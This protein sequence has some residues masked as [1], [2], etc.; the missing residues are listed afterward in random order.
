MHRFFIGLLCIAMLGNSA[1]AQ[2]PS[3]K[4]KSGLEVLFEKHLDLLRGKR[5]AL[6][7][8]PTGVNSKLESIIDL[9]KANP[10]IKLVAL[11]GPEHGIR[12]NAQAGEY[13]SYYFDQDFKLPVYSLYGSERKKSN[14][15]LSGIDE[16]M[17]SFDTQAT[18][19][20][21]NP[22]ILN[23]VNTHR[24]GFTRRG[25]S[26]LHLHCDHGLCFARLRKSQHSHPRFG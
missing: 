1:N 22:K 11:L 18:E 3:T 5:I 10:E 15:H 17:R 14:N 7:T 8:N 12:S 21:L 19:K 13:V 2:P 9:F 25:D 6:I 4:T 16:V 26:R 23:N 24:F 20:T